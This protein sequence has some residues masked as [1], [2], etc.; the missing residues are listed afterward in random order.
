MRLRLTTDLV[1]GLLFVSLGVF[2]I[3]Y[4]WTYPIGTPARIGPGYYPL[5]VASGLVL[6]GLILLGRALV[7]PGEPIEGI[8]L[9][10]LVFVLLGTALFGLLVEKAGFVIC[11]ILVVVL[12]R[13]ADRDFRPVE[14]ALLA[15]GLVAFIAL[16]FWLGLS[17]PL[18]P[19]PKW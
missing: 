15:A 2:A 18:H 8:A 14:V 6:L 11:G 5:L 4:G 17:L 13:L 7:T 10:P 1:T 12:A 16:L 9:R 19:F 3:V